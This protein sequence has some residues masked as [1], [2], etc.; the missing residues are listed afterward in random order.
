[1]KWS[2]SVPP[3][4]RANW[5]LC[6]DEQ[7][8][9]KLV[10]PTEAR[11]GYCGAREFP[12]NEDTNTQYTTTRLAKSQ[13]TSRGQTAR[14]ESSR[15]PSA[16][17]CRQ[18]PSPRCV[19]GEIVI[20]FGQPASWDEGS[21]PRRRTGGVPFNGQGTRPGYGPAVDLTATVAGVEPWS[22]AYPGSAQQA[23]A[24]WLLRVAPGFVSKL[25]VRWSRRL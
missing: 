20:S 5:P 4:A 9:D 7:S 2:A 8:A 23:E 12:S 14:A 17:L 22:D 1:M 6:H 11:C 10:E 16:R 3:A 15:R 25:R 19:A 18:R 24:A 13:D 21:V